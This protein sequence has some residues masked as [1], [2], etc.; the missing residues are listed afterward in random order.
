MTA[1]EEL[2]DL[3]DQYSGED[4]AHATA[5]PRVFLHRASH[6]SLPL[7]TVYEP[8]VCFV[9]R[10]RKQAMA[11]DKLYTYSQGDYLIVSVDVPIV[12]QILDASTK[13]PFLCLRLDLDP[14]AIGALMLESD[15]ERAAREPPVS[16]LSVSPMG[17]KLIDAAVRLLRLLGTPGDIPILA[18]LAER[19]ILYRLLRGQQSSRMSQI[20]FAESKL[21]QVNRAIGWIK[22]YYRDPFSVETLAAEARMST[23]A[24]HQ[25]FKTVTGMSPLQYQKQLR[26]QEARRLILT[27]SIDSASAGH[28]VGYDS[29]SQFSRE[30]RRLFGAPP[31]RDIA[32]LRA[33]AIGTSVA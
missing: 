29:P 9:A 18:P 10:G 25:H 24:L 2:A 17:D 14:G 3:I 19:E 13:D 4:G 30:Y 26:L 6:V 12:S 32:R 1:M 11:G 21:Q 31:G 15:A 27:Q 16:S 8:A 22:T 28:T 33:S 5:I 23:S 20:A 7:H